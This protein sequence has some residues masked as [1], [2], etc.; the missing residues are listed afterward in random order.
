[1]PTIKYCSGLGPKPCSASLQ[2]FV[3]LDDESAHAALKVHVLQYASGCARRDA[4][5]VARARRHFRAQPLD[6]T[7][8]FVKI[9]ASRVIRHTQTPERHGTRELLKK[10]RGRQLEGGGGFS[11]VETANL[12]QEQPGSLS[13][14]C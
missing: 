2:R 13:A 8:L 5:V 11:E 6:L 10:V 7:S 12:G 1:M 14:L 3:R 4:P 9:N